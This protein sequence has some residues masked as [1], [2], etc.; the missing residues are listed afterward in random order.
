MREKNFVYKLFLPL[1]C[2]ILI[3]FYKNCNSLEKSHPPQIH[4]YTH[5]D[6]QYT[7]EPVDWDPYKCIYTNWHVLIEV[8]FITLNG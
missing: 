6:T 1:I 5:K 8:I 2:Q 7:Q 4:T 3:I